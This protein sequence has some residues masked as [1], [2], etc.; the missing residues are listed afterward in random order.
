LKRWQFT[1]ALPSYRRFLSLFYWTPTLAEACLRQAGDRAAQRAADIFQQCVLGQGLVVDAPVICT[2]CG[3]AGLELWDTGQ[4][5]G[6]TL[7]EA[8]YAP[9]V[10]AGQARPQ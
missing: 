7:G 5:W 6:E 8:W 2:D 4:T 3:A 10:Q 1:P 9:R